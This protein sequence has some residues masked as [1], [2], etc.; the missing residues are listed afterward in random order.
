MLLLHADPHYFYCPLL[1]ISPFVA[2]DNTGLQ[3]E[4]VDI[5]FVFVPLS[6]SFSFTRGTG[7]QFL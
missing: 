1:A 6:L 5:P 4:S 3:P 2:L 7:M